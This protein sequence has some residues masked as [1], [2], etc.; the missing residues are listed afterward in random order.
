MSFSPPQPPKKP[1]GDVGIWYLVF[2]V[3]ICVCALAALG[4]F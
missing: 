4:Q 3:F 1:L 2:C